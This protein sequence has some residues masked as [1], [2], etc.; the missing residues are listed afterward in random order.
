MTVTGWYGQGAHRRKLELSLKEID[1]E[2]KAIEREA[3][4]RF[5]DPA[6][7]KM[8]GLGSDSSRAAEFSD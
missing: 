6:R 1:P 3:A 5:P 7:R 4:D 2:L 8:L